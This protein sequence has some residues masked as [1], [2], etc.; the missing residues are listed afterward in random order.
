MHMKESI[1]DNVIYTNL[2]TSLG[3]KM[4]AKIKTSAPQFGIVYMRGRLLGAPPR[5]PPLPLFS[6]PSGART[7]NVLILIAN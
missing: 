6:R 1:S 7:K 2:S 3:V 4:G 5:A